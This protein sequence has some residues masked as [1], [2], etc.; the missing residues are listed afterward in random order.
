MT[1]TTHGSSRVCS[2][3]RLRTVATTSVQTATISL[4]R[5][6]WQLLS[7]VHDRRCSRYRFVHPIDQ[8]RGSA[9]R[10]R[11]GR[12]VCIGITPTDNAASQRTR[13]NCV[14]GSSGCSLCPDPTPGSER[15]GCGECCWPAT[16]IGVTRRGWFGGSPCQVVERHHIGDRGHGF[17]QCNKP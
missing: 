14:V 16:R 5:T 6:C 7:Q 17:G 10:H 13:P 15:R 1:M 2:A 8:G 4:P 12:S 3:A 11:R 9:A